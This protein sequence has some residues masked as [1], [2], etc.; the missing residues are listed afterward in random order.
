MEGTQTR[1]SAV[2]MASWLLL[3]A[4]TVGSAWCAYQASLW[5]G[6]QTQTLASAS[7]AQFAGVRKTA[8]VNRNVSVDV[9]TFLS[10][11]SAYLDGNVK[12]TRFLR[13]HARP[14]LKPALEAW[15]AEIDAGHTDVPLPFA[16]PEYHLA[17]QDEVT[18]LDGVVA[19]D[20]E[21]SRSANLDSDSY[22]LHTVLF[23]LALF[24]L[25]ATSQASRSGTRLAMLVLGALAFIGTVVSMARL[26]RAEARYVR[27]RA[28]AQGRRRSGERPHR[29]AGLRRGRCASR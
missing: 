3:A 28:A 22:V 5:N 1:R 12:T 9:G 18:A 10:Y 29:R 2:E 23:A 14:G 4:A 21:A 27:P 16:R 20:L 11:V 6:V 26:P 7:V 17:E 25:G 8:I 19:R 13:D 15:I 24:F